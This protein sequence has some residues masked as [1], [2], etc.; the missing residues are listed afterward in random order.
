M[1]LICGVLIASL[2]AS[3]AAAADLSGEFG[4]VSDYRYR[5]VTLSHRRPAVQG[6]VTIEDDSGLYAEAWASTLER[7]GD[8]TDSEVD[9][10]AGFSKDLSEALNVDL[11]G[12]FF[13]YPST[14]SDVL[15]IAFEVVVVGGL[16]SVTGT[17]VGGVLLAVAQLLG[18]RLFGPSYALVAGHL[19]F[20][21]VLLFRPQ[22]LLPR[23]AP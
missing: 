20:L 13:A 19:V 1:R 10:T 7:P 14:G 4:V 8:P 5:G 22:G 21:L 15:L 12:T 6:S 23:T 17:F 11:S 16:G 3:S 9:F 18:A 2:W